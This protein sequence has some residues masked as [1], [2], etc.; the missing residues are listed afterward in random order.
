MQ[1][2]GPDWLSVGFR[3]LTED[4]LGHYRKLV[5]HVQYIWIISIIENIFAIN[6]GVI[7][8]NCRIHEYPQHE[9]SSTY[10]Q[11]EVKL[12]QVCT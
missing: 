9:S 12:D 3:N 5:V 7:L 4:Y 2:R 6:F 11:N 10:R 8:R 1:A